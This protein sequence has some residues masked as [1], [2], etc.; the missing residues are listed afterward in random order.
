MGQQGPIGAKRRRFFRND[1]R[2]CATLKQVILDGFDL[3]VAPFGALKM[4][5]FGTKNGLK[6]V[7]KWVKNDFFK[8]SS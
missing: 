5:C 7:Q 1:P 3:V 2:P 6:L 8:T 4:G